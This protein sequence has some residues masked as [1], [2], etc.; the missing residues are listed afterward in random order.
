[1][2]KTA[3]FVAFLSAL[4][5]WAL[6]AQSQQV[7]RCGKTYSE[8]PCP[9]AVAIDTSDTRSQTQKKASQKATQRDKQLA[10]ELEE[11][12]KGEDALALAGN[13]PAADKKIQP[14]SAKPKKSKSHAAPSD[15]VIEAKAKSRK[16][17]KPEFFTATGPPTLKKTKQKPAQ[18]AP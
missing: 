9:G 11:K 7:Y 5:L 18:P 15:E 3:R 17:K 13:T 2:K 12:R 14:K 16:K 1:M 10:K 8:T 4:A 6:A